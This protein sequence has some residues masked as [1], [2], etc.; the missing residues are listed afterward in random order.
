LFA[1]LLLV[2]TVVA[3]GTDVGEPA[4]PPVT[5]T[6]TASPTTT[7]AQ[8]NEFGVERDPVVFELDTDITMMQSARRVIEWDR[9]QPAVDRLVA[10]HALHERR[11]GIVLTFGYA[12][13][14]TEGNALAASFNA[15]L[16]ERFPTTFSASALRTF[17]Q[18]ENPVG[19]VRVEVYVLRGVG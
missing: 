14:V 7:I 1:D 12:K 13:E 3:F 4:P 2:L 17:R 16:M 5:T 6:T 10:E 15:F 19:K 18:A 9:L 8:A 11:A